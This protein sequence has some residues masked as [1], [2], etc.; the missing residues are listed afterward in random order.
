LAPT[1]RARQLIARQR[2]RAADGYDAYVESQRTDQA[3]MMTATPSEFA[4]LRAA[5]EGAVGEA[6]WILDEMEESAAVYQLYRMGANYESN[7]R[8]IR[9]MKRHLADSLAAYRAREGREA[10]VLLKFGSVHVGRGYSPLNQLDLGNQAAELAYA[11][12]RESLHLTVI[13]AEYAT[14]GGNAIS[15]LDQAPHFAPLLAALGSDQWVVVDLRA[16][17]PYLHR[18]QNRERHEELA[19]MVF[20]YDAVI[21]TTVLRSS[22]DLVP[23]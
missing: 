8:R 6:T 18:R 12:G 9:L 2:R 23:D 19:Q 16:L 17:R 22:A 7:H 11:R 21:V 20:R 1:E 4:E 5:M 10:K 14:R 13:A 3:F 15:A